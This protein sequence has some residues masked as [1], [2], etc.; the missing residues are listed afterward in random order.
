M[1]GKF[2]GIVGVVSLVILLYILQ[3]TT[4]TE[5]GAV[6]VL[7]VFLLSYIAITVALTFFIFW[8]YRLVVK[9]FY[10][11]KLTTLEDAFS[12]RKSYYYSSILALGPVMMVS[13]R[14]VGKDGIVEYMMI[15][16]LLFLGCVYVSRQTS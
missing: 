11:D 16:F 3:T 13:L 12:L 8:L 14:S 15:V 4:P 5:A 2:I 7:A 10:S 6:G 1:L 9:V